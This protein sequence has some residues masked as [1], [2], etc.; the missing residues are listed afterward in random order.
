LIKNFIKNPHSKIL[1]IGDIILDKYLWGTCDRISPE[2]PVQ[3]IDIN[4]ESIV[5]GGAGNVANNLIA[6]GCHVE[7]ISVI[8]D[9]GVSEELISLMENIGINSNNLIKEKNRKSSLKTRIISSHQQVVRYDIESSNSISSQ[10]ESSVIK[11]LKK[12]IESVDLVILSDYMKGFFTN[13]LTKKIIEISN[14]YQKKVL[15]DPKGVDF[16]KYKNSYLLTPNKSEASMALNIEIKDD[17]TLYTALNKMKAD[18]NLGISIITLSEKGIATLGENFKIHPTAAREVFDVTGAGDTVIAALGYS[19]ANNLELNEAVE[20]ANIAAG[21]VVGKIGAA[22]ATFDEIMNHHLTTSESLY[23][24]KIKSLDQICNILSNRNGKKVVFTNGCF[25]ILH[26]GHITYL[27]KSKQLGEILI[28]AVN[29][30]DSVKKLKGAKRPIND[31]KDRLTLIA[32]LESVDFV[33][34]FDE[35]TPY[36]VIKQISPDIL[37]KGGDYKNKEVSG[38][39]LVEQVVLI[40]FIENKSS[41]GIIKKILENA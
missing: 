3:V 9:C 27:E 5:L 30:N 10:S 39:D 35:E 13:Y 37:V 41:T 16:E 2:A 18:L 21:V 26:A 38:Q 14:S 4:K 25:D 7:L 15:V 20:F 24:N 28:V 19:L 11:T 34:E 32:A 40:D 12:I 1:V 29:S 6:L 23:E 36:N 31:I 8:G 22:T 33:V 17:K